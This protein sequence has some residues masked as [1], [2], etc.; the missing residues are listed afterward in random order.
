MVRGR[1][2]ELELDAETDRVGGARGGGECND[3]REDTKWAGGGG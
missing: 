1:V 2:G 3:A